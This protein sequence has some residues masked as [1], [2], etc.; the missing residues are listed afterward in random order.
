M[1]AI[2]RKRLYVIA[3]LIALMALVLVCRLY[4]L[5]VVRG[6]ELSARADQQYVHPNQSLYDRGSIYLQDESGNLIS[7]AT[8]KSGYTVSIRPESIQSPDTVYKQLSEHL[9]IDRARFLSQARKTDDPY[10]QIAS[11]VSEDTKDAVEA[12][13]IDG[14]GIHKQ[15]WRFYP[16]ETLAAQTLG[17][18]AY[19]GDERRGVYGLERYYQDVLERDTSETYVNFFAEIFANLNRTI[20]QQDGYRSGDVVTTL[21]PTVQLHIQEQIK[22]IQQEWDSTRTGA[23]VMDPNTGDIVSMAVYPTF[24]VNQYGSVGD[25]ELYKNPL[26]ESVYEMGSIIKPITMAAGLD[27]GVVTAETTFTDRGEVTYNGATI[28]NWDGRAHGTVTMQTVLNKS[29]NTGA[30]YVQQQLGNEQFTEYMRSFELG[31]ETGIDLPNEAHGLMS[32]LDSSRDIEHATASF[33]QGI[34]MTPIAT[35][36]ALAALANGGELITPHVAEKIQL[37]SGLTRSISYEESQQRVISEAASDEITR[38]LV[39][40]VDEALLGGDESLPNHSVAAKTGT[41]QIAKPSGDGYYED[42]FLHS[43]FGYFP[44]YEPR[45]IAFFYTVKPQGAKYSSQTL[46]RPFLDTA[47]FLINYYDIPPDRAAQTTEI[48]QDTP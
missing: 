45:Y 22:E 27:A 1:Q 44:A 4:F 5:Q 46:A 33:G 25:P 14:V 42:E 23:I 11:R 32:N 20:F 40:V 34:A 15:R 35:V 19:H 21:E 6:E 24:N 10:E 37:E 26:V 47:Q 3:G 36:R 39:N 8:L 16:G 18:V 28:K 43:F 13:G 2:A 38:M 31:Q 12:L 41:A 7:G 48:S 9:D 17:F 29:L 30:A